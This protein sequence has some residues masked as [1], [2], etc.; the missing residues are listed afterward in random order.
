MMQTAMSPCLNF[1]LNHRHVGQSGPWDLC[2]AVV[3]LEKDKLCL[4]DLFYLFNLGRG[5]ESAAGTKFFGNSSDSCVP[6][7]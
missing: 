4:W 7:I 2:S 1:V 6:E 5:R 3:F